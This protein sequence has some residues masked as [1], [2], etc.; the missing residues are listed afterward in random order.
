MCLSVVA[1]AACALRP[2]YHVTSLLRK[3]TKL[4]HHSLAPRSTQHR[5]C[6]ALRP[7]QVDG[8][9]DSSNTLCGEHALPLSTADALR[10]IFISRLKKRKYDK[11]PGLPTLRHPQFSPGPAIFASQI[12]RPGPHPS[13]KPSLACLRRR[14]CGD[15]RN[16]S[17][18]FVSMGQPMR[19]KPR[20]P[21][22]PRSRN[23]FTVF[24]TRTPVRR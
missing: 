2:V 1:R 9:H 10:D 11:P 14:V 17:Q 13:E 5:R 20:I 6:I 16:H 18:A 8:T 4:S 23:I 15:L 19:P 24:V 3:S 22:R 12:S 7:M 21:L